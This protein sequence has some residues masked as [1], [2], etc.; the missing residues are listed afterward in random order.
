MLD[1]ALQQRIQGHGARRRRADV[2]SRRA[3]A[4]RR[5]RE[6]QERRQARARHRCASRTSAP[7]RRP[8]RRRR[9]RPT[10]PRSPRAERLQ[11]VQALDARDA[12]RRSR[13]RARR[14]RRACRP[15]V[16]GDRRPGRRAGRRAVRR[17]RRRAA[18]RASLQPTRR[19]NA[20]GPPPR[21]RAVRADA[22]AAVAR[23]RGRRGGRRRAS[24]AEK[25]AERRRLRLAELAAEAESAAADEDLASAR[26]RLA[27]V[28]R[29]WKDLAAGLEVDAEL[30]ARV[31]AAEARVRRARRGSRTRQ[32]ARARREALAPAAAARSAAS[33]R[34]W[35]T[36]R[37]VAQGGRARAARHPR[38]AR[39]TCR[40]CRP[41]AT[42]TRSSQRL[43]AAQT[44]LMPK[45]QE[46]REAEDWQRWANV[47][48]Q[49]Q[50][51][52]KMEALKAVEDPEAIARQIRELQEQWRQAAD[53][54]RAQGDALWRR[55]KAAHDEL[56]TRCE[57]HFA[58]QAEQRAARTSRRRSRSASAPK[59]SPTRPTGFRPPTRSRSCRPS[60]RR[61]ARS[62]AARKRPI[63]ER[64]RAACDRFF[65]RRQ[66]DLAARKAVW[67]E[68]L[69]KK[70]ALCVQAEALADSTDWD[71][72]GGRDQ[73]AAGRVEDD[74]AG[75][76]EPFGG[77]L[78]ALPRRLRSR[79]SRATRSATTSRAPSASRRAKRSAPSSKRS[80]RHRATR[81]PRRPARS[82][83]P[84]ICSRRSARCAAA[85]SSEIA[86]RGVDR[87]RA[88][89]LDQRFAAAFAGVIARWP[90]VF[91]GTDL[92][93]EANRK[94]HGNARAA[95]RGSRRVARRAPR[96]SADA[97]LS[98]TTRLAAMLKE[99]LAAN[100]IGG[101]VDDDSRWRAA[102][103]DV[104]QAQAAWSRIGPVPDAGAPRARRPLPARVPAD[105]GRGG[106]G[107]TA[108]TGP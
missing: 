99:A 40:R 14:A 91:G 93:P 46:L 88:L 90:A 2:R 68:N 100:T 94:K 80:R 86:A 19:P 47:G 29:E 81:R 63:W 87:E 56:W 17:G 78:A 13:R 24:L 4:D 6:E 71:A 36:P 26:R 41:S 64:F 55:F 102:A 97:A 85:G 37:S 53:V 92:D 23:G 60:G 69:A 66:A 107:R 48:V 75:E 82:S 5:A 104:R 108:A 11:L 16:V 52:A 7:R 32:D 8:P 15:R 62:R 45:V 72:D 98:P 70:E 22:D 51:C 33:S 65:T 31:A 9:R 76:E 74:R 27:L 44:A 77:D 61:S 10:P 12:V 34:S 79:S 84:P 83:R 18:A 54:P 57:A 105:H 59:R 101:K 43:K 28:R 42:T 25:D 20:R 50:L 49:E 38:G 67:A 95:H 73:A 21:P 39:P 58:A 89:A 106:D 35:L 3:R 1:V 103:E 30:A 96:P